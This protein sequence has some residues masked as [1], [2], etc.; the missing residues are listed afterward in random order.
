[1]QEVAAPVVTQLQVNV[2]DV[3]QQLALTSGVIREWVR[4]EGGQTT[5]SPGAP[6]IVAAVPPGSQGLLTEMI[7][8]GPGV[9]HVQSAELPASHPLARQAS[10]IAVEQQ[11]LQSAWQFV[12]WAASWQASGRT[13]TRSSSDFS[14]SFQDVPQAPR[15]VPQEHVPMVIVLQPVVPAAASEPANQ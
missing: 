12:G 9:L 10:A 3:G 1:V 4:Q 5:Q 11:W 2:R 7:K 6:M 13:Q 14:V 15:I 8:K